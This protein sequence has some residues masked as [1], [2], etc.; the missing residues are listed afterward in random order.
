VGM[1]ARAAF[2]LGAFLSLTVLWSACLLLLDL[3]GH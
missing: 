3:F 2:F 1:L